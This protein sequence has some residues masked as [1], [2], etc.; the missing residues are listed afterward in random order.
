MQNNPVDDVLG[1]IIAELLQHEGF[2]RIS[3]VALNCLVDL[4]QSCRVVH[5]GRN[6]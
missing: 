1:K 5:M 3:T 2:N 6:E 4:A